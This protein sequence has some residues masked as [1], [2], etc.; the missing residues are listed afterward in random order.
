MFYCSNP[1]FSEQ[2]SDGASHHSLMSDP[3]KMHAIARV[4]IQSIPGGLGVLGGELRCPVHLKITQRLSVL[5]WFFNH[6]FH[7]WA[8][9]LRHPSLTHRHSVVLSSD[10]IYL[11]HSPPRYYH[12][13]L[14]DEND[15]VLVVTYD[16]CNDNHNHCH[17]HASYPKLS[18]NP[19]P[20]SNAKM[21]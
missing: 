8:A 13:H 18:S 12:I 17:H 11:L 3:V 4:H 9:L 1:P 14:N 19:A 10:M 20:W 21:C 6:K 7:R 15:A 2:H 16:S 5:V